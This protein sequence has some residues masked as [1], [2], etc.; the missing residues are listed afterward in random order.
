MEIQ[1]ILGP[2][3][4][5][6][7]KYAEEVAV[8][9]GDKLIYLATMIPRNEDN[10]KR[11]EKH[12]I[13]RLNKGF[14]T[15]EAGWNIGEIQVEP[16]TVVLLEDASNLVANGMFMHGADAEVALQDI[17]TLAGRCKKLIVVSIGGLVAEG[18]DEETS[19][20]IGQLNWLNRRLQEEANVVT[21]MSVDAED[22]TC[23]SPIRK[24]N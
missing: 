12:R 4:S 15:I 8:A 17:L 20:Y 21:E 23:C 13:Q 18:Y 11:I 22:M 1:L 16:D 7:S 2:N 9:G 3:N 6:K 19:Y 5:G 14:Q 24:E 10:R